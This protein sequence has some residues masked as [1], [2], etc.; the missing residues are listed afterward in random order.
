MLYSYQSIIIGS[1][2]LLLRGIRRM[3]PPSK[4][5]VKAA[6]L[7]DVKSHFT[8]GEPH[9]IDRC[10]GARLRERRDLRGVTQSEL[11]AEVGVTRRKL[12]GLAKALASEAARF[13]AIASNSRQ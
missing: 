2:I 1:S 8:Q 4:L 13:G 5:G 9:S 12:I 10:V 3:E 6:Q 7:L 11:G